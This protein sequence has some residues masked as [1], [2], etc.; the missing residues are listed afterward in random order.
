MNTLI[1]M[2]S[3]KGIFRYTSKPSFEVT[4]GV[5]QAGGMDKDEFAKYMESIICLYPNA[6]DS[7]GKQVI[8]KLDSGPG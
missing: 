8:I 6:S 7:P 4:L 1:H 3:M 5:N 2:H